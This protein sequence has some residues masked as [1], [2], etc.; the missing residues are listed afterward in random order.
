MAARNV[1]K[2][3]KTNTIR[4]CNLRNIFGGGTMLS[5]VDCKMNSS[6]QATRE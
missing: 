5:Y 1:K 2:E 4:S 6:V 3:R